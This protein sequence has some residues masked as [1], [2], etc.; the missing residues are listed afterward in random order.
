MKKYYVVRS[1]I[2]RL[3]KPST[4]YLHHYVIGKPFK[5]FVVDHI[6]GD[7][8]NNQI[9][10]LRIVTHRQNLQN[11]KVNRDGKLCGASYRPEKGKW[12]AYMRIGKK[13]KS[14]GYYVTEKEAHLVYMDATKRNDK[15]N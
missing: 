2:N 8:L 4:E 13:T 1:N 11:K 7:P 6:D 9:D 14:L 3:G 12:Q 5:G 15:T 10:N